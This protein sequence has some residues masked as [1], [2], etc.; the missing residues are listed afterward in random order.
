MARVFLFDG[1]G[2]LYRAYF[3]IDQNL[4]TTKGIP[5]NSLYGLARMLLKF[6]KENIKINED[7]CGFVLD[8]KGGSTYRKEL[9]DK[10]KIHR[11]ETPEP[12]L[13]QIEMADEL[14]EGFGIKVL[15]LPGYEADDI[16]ATLVSI[17]EKDRLKYNIE[18][19]NIITSD[20]DMLQLVNENVHV[21]RIEKGV[22]DIKKYTVSEVIERFGVNPSQIKEYLALVGDTSDNIPGVPG[23]GEKTAIKILREFGGIEEALKNTSKIPEKVR[24]TLQAYLKDY[25]LSRKLIELNTN[26]EISIEP[27]SLLYTGL[28]EGKLLEV[29]KKFEF[30]SIIKEL[31]LSTNLLK[32]ADYKVINDEK[33]FNLLIEEILKSKKIAFDLETTSLDPYDGKIVGISIAVDEGRA[34]YV[35]IAHVGSK[36]LGA[37]Q[38]RKLFELLFDGTKSLGGHN[39]KFDMKFLRKIGIESYTPSFDTMIEAYLLNPNEKRFN[40]DEL[41]LKLLGHKMISYEDVVKSSLPLFVGDFSYVPVESAARYS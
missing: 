21:W 32:K 22:T 7:Y 13:K 39:V 6:I 19:I 16:I 34:F 26:V 28:R 40:L 25:E 15:K 1:T 9:Y 18:E 37:E 5:T 11:P 12:L 20:K 17:F 30:S 36:N 31:N 35:P 41:S 14:V 10:Y 27:K 8:V 2:L 23:V 24:Q 38:S 4:S 29:L 3:A 33:T